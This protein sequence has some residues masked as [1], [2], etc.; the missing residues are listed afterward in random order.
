MTVLITIVL[1]G[2]ALVLLIP[3][4]VLLSEC[5]AAGWPSFPST[6]IGGQPS[7][8]AVLM[9]AHNEE[10][11]I[12]RTLKTIL[13][14]LRKG[15]RLIVVADN[16]EDRTAD[17]VKELGATVIE[18]QNSTQRGKGYAIDFGLH[19]LA[20]DPPDVVILI[21]ADSL[22]EPETIEQLA[23]QAH[24]SG[25]PVQA[26]YIM[27][28]PQN[29]TARDTV[30]ALA[31]LV[32]NQVRAM[33]LSRLGLP[34]LLAGTG[35]AFP[36]SVLKE[37]SLATGNIVEDMQLGIDLAIAGHPPIFCP[38]AKVIGILPQQEQTAKTQ[39]TRWEHGHLQTLSTQVPR[40]LKA[41]IVQ[42][43]LDLLSLAL[44]LGVPPLSFLVMLWGTVLILGLLAGLLSGIWLP[45]LLMMIAGLFL[46][47]A[48][49]VAWYTFGRPMISGK[50]LLN[51]PFY[52]VWKIPLYF[53]FLIRPEQKW[54][55]TERDNL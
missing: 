52:L 6:Q 5:L 55:K 39:R 23:R 41:A 27:E 11:M 38:Q 43:R 37:A 30:S 25:K 22:V 8:I 53:A 12:E 16:C 46:F 24:T 34:C 2:L 33:G 7:Q 49:S 26:T 28:Y 45:V 21:D 29:P 50:A 10:A 13:P 3:C 48:I 15:D 47:L 42:K 4:T 9:P 1:V 44:E 14:Q 18:R 20:S 17:L 31:F 54:I 35:M 32:K 51:I 19:F 40:L 36:W